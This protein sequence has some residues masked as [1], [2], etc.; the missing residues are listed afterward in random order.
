[1]LRTVAEMK[2]NSHNLSNSSS[3]T[4][5][6][7]DNY[8]KVLPAQW[9]QRLI[10]NEVDECCDNVLKIDGEWMTNY[11]ARSWNCQGLCLLLIF[12]KI[13]KTMQVN[14]NVKG[15][16]GLVSGTIAWLLLQ[17]TSKI[18][19]DVDAK[20]MKPKVVLHQNQSAKAHLASF[21]REI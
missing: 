14:F 8:F 4:F 20:L 5:E 17:N 2:A 6:T 1:M 16:F 21:E 11:L 7:A 15:E 3:D 19:R 12:N 10:V 18:G 9:Q 13:C